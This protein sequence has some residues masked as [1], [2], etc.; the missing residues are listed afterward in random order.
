ISLENDVEDSFKRIF[1]VDEI[2]RMVGNFEKKYNLDIHYSGLPFTRT[3]IGEIIQNELYLF[4]FLASIVTAILLL[5]FFRSFKVV[6]FSLIIV[7]TSVVWALGTLYLFGFHLTVLSGMI[8]PLLIVIG[9]PNIVFLLNKYHNEYKNHGNKIKSLQRVVSKVGGAIF[10]TNLTTAAGFAT[11]IITNSRLL[12]EF[13]IV[14]AINIMGIFFIS[15]LLVPIIFSFIAPPKKKQT[16]HLENKRIKWVINKFCLITKNYRKTLYGFVGVMIVVCIIGI[17]Q[18]KTTG[19]LVDDISKEDPV[20]TDLKFFETEINGVIPIEIC[21]DTKKRN[22]IMNVRF[23]QNLDELQTRLEKIPELSKS[24]S[25]AN[26]IKFAR[27]AYYNGKEDQY[28]LPSQ[29]EV[30]F[31]LAYMAGNKDKVNILS[32]FIDSTACKARLS[33]FVADIGTKRMEELGNSLIRE[34][35]SIFPPSNYDTIVTGSCFLY[36]KG[37]TYLIK[38]LFISL[39]L[40]I[41]LISIFMALMFSS[42][43][44]VIISLIPNILPLLFTAAI[45][46]YFGIAIKPSTLLVFSIAF[47]ISV[48]NAI[49]FLAKYGQEL[50]ATKQNIGKS[51]ILAL[52]EAGISIIYTGII[53]FFGFAIFIA[54]KFGGTQALGVLIAITIMLA[55]FAN[56]LLLP[57]LLFSIE[58]IIGRKRSKEE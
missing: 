36:T 1:V 25:V 53:L 14:A 40:A 39:G 43:R 19:Y 22:G 16:K 58:K 57:S 15:L 44:M 38:N 29:A 33:L 12:V 54:S 2:S 26:G 51:V 35:N 52:K 50:K 23:L 28:K 30:N 21:I 11:F 56:L 46:G 31:I 18:M 32:S 20:Y 13:G 9:I 7:G 4:I 34:V 10:L 37:T 27:Q 55:V 3:R 6:L 17:S 48:D 8:P 42:I 41:I 45:M 5:L 49:H 24:I 47:G